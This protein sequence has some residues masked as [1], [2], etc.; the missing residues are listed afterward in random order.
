MLMFKMTL[1]ATCMFILI[2]HKVLLL[3]FTLLGFIVCFYSILF[4]ECEF[5]SARNLAVTPTS[6]HS[7][8]GTAAPWAQVSARPSPSLPR[9]PASMAAAADP[10]THPARSRL[11]PPFPGAL[12]RRYRRA[13]HPVLLLYQHQL[14]RIYSHRD[15]INS[16]R[17]HYQRPPRRLQAHRFYRRRRQYPWANV[18]RRYCQPCSHQQVFQGNIF[19]TRSSL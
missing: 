18:V 5:A 16:R 4:L 1:E 11:P 7:Q 17:H 12:N 19:F 3:L 2:I 10:S 14:L 8:P 13:V 6:R 15:E 9:Q